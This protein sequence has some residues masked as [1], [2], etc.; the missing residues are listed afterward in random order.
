MKL[1]EVVSGSL[2]L[3]G[4]FVGFAV[5]AAAVTIGI[6]LGFLLLEKLV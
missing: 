1:S 4:V 3:V 2:G 6:Y 5:V